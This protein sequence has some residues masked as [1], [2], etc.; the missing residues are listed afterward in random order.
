MSR[1]L[2]SSVSILSMHDRSWISNPVVKKVI[3]HL[4]QLQKKQAV[5][6]RTEKHIMENVAQTKIDLEDFL[7]K[8]KI[9]HN[10]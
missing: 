9:I 3:V 1:I 8:P 6:M 2:P 4:V 5:A 7:Q 10:V